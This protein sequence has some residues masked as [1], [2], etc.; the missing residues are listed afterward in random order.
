MKLSVSHLPGK[1][2]LP[3]VMTFLVHS[4]LTSTAWPQRHR[5]VLVL[6]D[7]NTDFPSLSLLD[8]SLKAAFKAG[9]PDGIDLY[10]ESMD[11]ARFQDDRYME[12]LRAFYGQKYATRRIDLVIAVMGPA[13][14]FLLRY[15]AELFSGAPMVFCGISWREIDGRDLGPNVTGV[16]MQREFKRTLDLALRLQRTPARW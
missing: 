2:F 11:L 7:E 6:Y 1:V 12:L 13:L 14:D 3:L 10:T 9:L 15:G 4:L 8:R 16:L 5:T